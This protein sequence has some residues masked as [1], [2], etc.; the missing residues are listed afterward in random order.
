M[1][2]DT[3]QKAAFVQRAAD[4]LVES[5]AREST[6]TDAYRQ[7]DRFR[8]ELHE[9]SNASLARLYDLIWA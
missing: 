4:K 6:E 5:Y 3:F 1:L 8:N 9:L 2:R 7:A